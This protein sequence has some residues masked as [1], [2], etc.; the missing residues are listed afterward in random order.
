MLF[1]KCS[2]S[3]GTSRGQCLDILQVSFQ[4][5]DTPTWELQSLK[6]EEEQAMGYHLS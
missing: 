6:A 3:L 2:V 5:E 4:P 1:Y